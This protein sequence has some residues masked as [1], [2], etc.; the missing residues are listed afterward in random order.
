MSRQTE[1]FCFLVT[2]STYVMTSNKWV[3][4]IIGNRC[5][6][7]SVN[8]LRKEQLGTYSL[9]RA[10][11]GVQCLLRKWKR[12]GAKPP[13]WSLWLWMTVYAPDNLL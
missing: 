10:L 5:V 12:N 13:M 6:C 9:S 8:S 1:H 4:S 11:C 7:P 2:F 3:L